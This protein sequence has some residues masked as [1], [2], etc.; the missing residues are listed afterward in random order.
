MTELVTVLIPL[1]GTPLTPIEKYVLQTCQKHLGDFPITFLKSES[2]NLPDEVREICP[3][4]DSVSYDPVFFANRVNYTKFLL[5]GGLY[6]QFSW[7][8][9]LLI[10]ELNSAIT[11]NELAYWCRQGY[12]FIQPIPAKEIPL[13]ILGK[14]KRKFNPTSFYPAG[15]EIKTTFE[16]NSGISLRRVKAFQKLVA[17]RKRTINRFLSNY[18]DPENDSLFWEYYVNRWRPELITPNSLARAHFAQ[19][20][21]ALKAAPTANQ[22]PFS[23]TNLNYTPD[24]DFC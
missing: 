5:G 11:K 18:P 16:R 24:L 6:E 8:R 23:L 4:A 13:S 19:P 3:D 12:D 2:L 1:F 21:A 20:Q 9:Y 14:L 10:L 22:V 15:S 17:R 7:S